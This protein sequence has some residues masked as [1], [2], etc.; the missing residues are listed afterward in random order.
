MYTRQSLE[1]DRCIS[2]AD[3]RR[4]KSACVLIQA[5]G[6]ILNESPDEVSR[7]GKTPKIR[8][9]NA[10]PDFEGQVKLKKGA[11]S[12]PRSETSGS[13]FRDGGLTLESHCPPSRQS[14]MRETNRVGWT[15]VL[16]MMRH[17]RRDGDRYVTPSC[18]TLTSIWERKWEGKKK[19]IDKIIF[20]G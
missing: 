15:S 1:I 19:K 20:E 16:V 3:C 18:V 10:V 5:N 2:S 6:Q 14:T 8:T 4:C 9:R 12:K 13:W 7:I 11:R 17:K